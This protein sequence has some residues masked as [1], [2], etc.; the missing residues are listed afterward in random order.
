M[1]ENEESAATEGDDR[2]ERGSIFDLS[3]LTG[4]QETT[5][6]GPLSPANHNWMTT[7]IEDL[8]RL[9]GGGV[10]PGRLLAFSAPSDTQG[11]LLVKQLMAAHDS[12]Y[13]STLRPEWEVEASLADYLQ[14]AGGE[15]AGATETRAEHLDPKTRLR[16]TASYL[17]RLETP[18]MV[19]MD[20]ADEFEDVAVREYADFLSHVKRRLWNTGSVGLMYCID[21]PAPPANRQITLRMA[22]I[23]WQLRRS[24]SSENIEYL[25]D[26]AKF[27]GGRAL[28]E[29]IKLELTD[30]VRVDTSRDIS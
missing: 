3:W 22:D 18:V 21:Q 15:L 26:V 30:E 29:P 14:Q 5:D 17:D 4:T 2:A 25:L 12:L 6:D 1:G 28:T 24:I 9:L 16:E 19:V 13:L 11:E 20:A 7:G 23:V 8:D 10:P 27:R